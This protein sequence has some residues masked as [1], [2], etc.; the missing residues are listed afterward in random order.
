MGKAP[1]NIPGEGLDLTYGADG[2][3][4][5]VGLSS[6]GGAA[7]P[8]H[9]PLVAPGNCSLQSRK[10]AEH[11]KPEPPIPTHVD[12]WLGPGCQYRNTTKQ[13][14]GDCLATQRLPSP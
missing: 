2:R 12:L 10:L 5:S 6:P 7:F 14:S 8:T 4:G 9:L 1:G 3:P 11:A 13:R